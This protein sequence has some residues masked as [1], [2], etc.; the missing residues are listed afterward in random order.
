MPAEVPSEAI[1]PQW[2]HGL[3][4]ESSGCYW[5]H[6]TVPPGGLGRLRR[7]WKDSRRV[8]G[9]GCQSA[10]R[11]RLSWASPGSR[12]SFPLFL[13]PT[14]LPS[15]HVSLLHPLHHPSL[16]L[17]SS[18]AF[19]ISSNISLNTYYAWSRWALRGARINQLCWGVHHAG[20]GGSL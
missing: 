2:P 13:A 4:T 11:A 12:S 1:T 9:R 7:L 16:F 18:I 14:S 17:I 6:L 5:R 19:F 15:F 20:R 8:S 10:L 3:H